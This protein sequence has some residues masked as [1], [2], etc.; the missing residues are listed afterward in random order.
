MISIYNTNFTTPENR[1]PYFIEVYRCVA[2]LYTHEDQDECG[3]DNNN[4]VPDNWTKIEIVVPD[5]GDK[6]EFY[7]YVIYNH[8]SCICTNESKPTIRNISEH[9]GE[10]LQFLI[11][12]VCLQF[13]PTL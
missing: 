10:F 7:K 6:T 4:I 8:T 1:D 11:R 12:D 9:S 2:A 13:L 5:L 3:A